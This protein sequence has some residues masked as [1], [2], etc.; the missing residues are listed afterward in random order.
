VSGAA[1]PDDDRVEGEELTITN[2]FTS[3]RV[4]KVSTRNGERLEISSLRVEHA[5]RLDA[6]L[7]ESLTWRDMADL[8][9]GLETPWGPEGPEGDEAAGATGDA[10]SGGDSAGADGGAANGDKPGGRDA[11][12]KGKAAEGDDAP[13]GGAS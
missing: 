12:G 1:Q 6:L 11:A 2:E 10:A 7:L 9:R 8:A 13:T 4:R 3:V 5:V